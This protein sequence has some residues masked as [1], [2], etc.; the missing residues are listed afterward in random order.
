M[1]V[2]NSGVSLRARLTITALSMGAVAIIAF[3]ILTFGSRMGATT[4]ASATAIGAK[5]AA[6]NSS[7]ASGASQADAIRKAKRMAAT[8]ASYFEVNQGQT[9]PSVKLS[10]TLR[11]LFDV[12][13]R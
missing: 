7:V 10:L 11:T 12:P 2:G 13:D 6:P 4:T 5:T 1:T 9:D 3:T 8:M